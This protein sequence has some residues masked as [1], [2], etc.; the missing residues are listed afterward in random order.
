[1]G[2]FYYFFRHEEY[3][4]DYN[5]SFYS[6]D[7]IPIERRR[8]FGFGV[9]LLVLGV[10]YEVASLESHSSLLVQ[11]LYI[12]CIYALSRKHVRE[13]SVCYEIMLLMS[14][15]DVC[16]LPLTTLLPGWFSINGWMFCSSPTLS[17]FAGTALLATWVPYTSTSIILTL[18]RCLLFTS[19]ADIFDGRKRFVWL[20]FPVVCALLIVAFGDSGLYNSVYGAF[21]FGLSSS[22]ASVYRCLD[23]HL[24]YHTDTSGKYSSK[25]QLWN[26][27]FFCIAQPAIYA[28]FIWR[29]AVARSRQP[30]RIPRREKAL[31]VQALLVNLTIVAAALGYTVMQYVQLPDKFIALSHLAWVIIEG[32]PSIIYLS[33]NKTIRRVLLVETKWSWRL[34]LRLGVHPPNCVV[35]TQNAATRAQPSVLYSKKKT[36]VDVSHIT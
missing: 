23:P 29:Y 26:N 25:I 34:Q 10:I 3:L 33:S 31:F 18:N 12:P 32:T 7:E 22:T 8:H 9:L 35:S 27:I 30:L 16:S 36:A 13:S 4:R 11:L 24:G 17:Y 14:I 19:Y 20:G 5:C 2:V 28:A 15:F 6:V 21:F 1:M